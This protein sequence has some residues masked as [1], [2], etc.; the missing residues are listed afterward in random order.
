MQLELVNGPD[1]LDFVESCSRRVPEE[2]AVHFFRQLLEAVV[3]M[4]KMGV[5]HRDLKPE[6]CMIDLQT[7][8]LKVRTLDLPVLKLA[9]QH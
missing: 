4:H 5:A 1:L 6:N 3:Y 7:H 9:R 8:T 2:V